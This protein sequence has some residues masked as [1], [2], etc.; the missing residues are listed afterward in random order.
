MNVGIGF[1]RARLQYVYSILRG[2]DLDTGAFSPERRDEQFAILKAA[3]DRTLNL[4]YWHDF[5]KAIIASGYRG[6]RLISSNNNLLFAYMLYLIGRT[7]YSVAE[8]ELRPT[9]ARWFFMAS[10]TGRY[11][12]SP[13]SAME[14]DLARFRD[15][16]TAEEFT[17]ILTRVCDDA[18]TNDFWTITLPNELATSSPQS[19][20]LFAY[21]AALAL[22]EAKAFFSNMSIVDLLDPSVHSSRSAVERH[23]LVPKDCLKIR[24]IT[25]LRETNQIANYALVEWKDNDLIG[26]SCPA[27]YLPQFLAR[28]PNPADRQRYYYWHALPDGW[29]QMEYG[30]FLARR[31]ERIAR[32][33]ADAYKRLSADHPGDGETSSVSIQELVDGGETLAVEFK[34]AL[35]VNLHM[36]QPDPRIELSCLKTIAG[37]LNSQHGGTLIIGVAD[38]G[39][40]V[41][42]SVDG[43]S[44]EDKMN[45]HL[46]N[47]LRDRIG[48]H[49]MLYIH[50][51]FADYEGHRVLVVECSPAGAPA[52]VKDGNTERLYIRGGAS[53]AE[54][55]GSQAQEYIKRRFIA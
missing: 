24:R 26:G 15:M 13:E 36:G 55:S 16:R 52:F 22:L 48:P 53:T 37:F 25:E 45:L 51:H 19:P 12:G 34:S 30:E 21:Y 28:Y 47:I 41:G 17:G 35:R 7:E 46:V 31:R 43:F 29:E 18:L 5:M 14:F 40:P 20:S 27:E 49:H 4:L 38:D 6:G 33:I 2:K 42:I 50:P 1:K 32:V 11:T 23:H 39:T 9:I 3:Q 10:L 8:I 54:L 44:S